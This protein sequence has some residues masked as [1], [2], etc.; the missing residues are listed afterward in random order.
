MSILQ[1]LRNL[2]AAT[3]VTAPAPAGTRKVLLMTD[4][5]AWGGA[6]HYMAT[7]ATRLDRSR[8]W[9]VV[10]MIRT[11]AT[12][13][14]FE[15]LAGG[16]GMGESAKREEGSGKPAPLPVMHLSTGGRYRL[17]SLLKCLWW[18]ARI[19]P[20]VIHFTLQG[21]RSLLYPA[22]AASMLGLR[23]VLCEQGYHD[24]QP[25]TRWE[26]WLKRWLSRRALT[27]ICASV[28]ARNRL[29]QVY[30]IPR[31]RFTV[32]H[33]AVSTAAMPNP[34][35]SSLNPQ[36]RASARVICVA[37]MDEN[38]GQ[39]YLIEAMAGLPD[40]E[41]WLV[42]DGPTRAALE[43]QAA[44]GALRITHYA[45]RIRFLGQRTDVPQL[46]AQSDIFCLPSLTES[47]PF[48]VLEAMAA[49]LP[50][51]ATRV[52]GVPEAVA[53]GETGFLVEP[54]DAEG[55]R[56]KLR[57]LLNDAELRRRMGE[58]G[59]ARVEREF[60]VEAMLEKTTQIYERS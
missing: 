52:G 23:S 22:L 6:E 59:R 27:T 50:V 47:L 26:R 7:L 25:P 34:Q 9:P 43:Q 8:Y 48:S 58:A 35:P 18:F 28:E 4:A 11:E 21:S 38:K 54:R 2:F 30:G 39:R 36:P 31:E 51:V 33:N 16:K 44:D 55:L 60:S 57:L 1:T 19:E 45:S 41:L 12:A 10:A 5:V 13:A 53:D 56:E 24:L 46:L 42:G 32:I 29:E 15:E 37:R 14:A 49:G 3:P 17:R 20:D 40:A